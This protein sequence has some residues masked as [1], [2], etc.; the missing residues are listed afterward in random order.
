MTASFPI[1]SQ[2]L[3]EV[4]GMVRSAESILF[5]TGAGLSA[6]SGLPTYRGIGGLYEA[7]TTEEGISIE[8]AL[9]GSMMAE[10]PALCW[11]YIHQIENVCRG[12]QPGAAHTRIAELERRFA[13]VWVLT[14]NVDGLHRQAGSRNIIEI[15]GDVHSLGCTRCPSAFR[16]SDF[17]GLEIPPYCDS[18]GGLVR[19]K[20]V[21]FGEM[22]HADAVAT[23]DRELER[24]FDV[25]FSVGTTSVFPYIAWPVLQAV[26]AGRPAIEI[27]PGETSVPHLA[28]HRI[29]CGAADAMTRICDAL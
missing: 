19:P 3:T 10:N 18:C 26:R 6:D 23:M 5:V 8:D 9:S 21:L 28:T 2:L 7:D 29:R 24:G 4:A 11:K 22:L 25:A 16:V 27:N 14:Q 12:A 1:D 17:N 15:H 20:V 13:R